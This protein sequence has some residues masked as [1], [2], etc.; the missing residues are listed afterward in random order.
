M[1][2]EKLINDHDELFYAIKRK[3]EKK[4]AEQTEKS[5]SVQNTIDLDTISV[6]S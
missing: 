5:I 3:K 2:D 1:V 4:L 6:S